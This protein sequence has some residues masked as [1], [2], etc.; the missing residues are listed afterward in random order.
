M[1]LITINI[2]L[3]ILG[4]DALLLPLSVE[5]GPEPET[6]LKCPVPRAPVNADMV[7]D[8]TLYKLDCKAT[9]RAGHTLATGKTSATL[10][11][12]LFDGWSG[13][14]S[15]SDCLGG[16]VTG[17]TPSSGT[18]AVTATSSGTH[19][20]RCISKFE[21]CHVVG[22]GD[23]QY[24]NSC[25][26]FATC[27]QSGFYVRSCPNNLSFDDSVKRCVLKSSTCTY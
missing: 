20:G 24:C 15:F 16:S 21:D 6:L 23:F 14:S 19:T 26:N 8:Y 2:S 12:S 17:T 25:T 22:E 4:T 1:F 7:C 27:A 3:F 10:S 13:A 11:C 18:G 5:D 9:C